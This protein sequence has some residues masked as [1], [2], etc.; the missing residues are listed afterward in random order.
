V[1]TD[2]RQASRQAGK[3]ASKQAG[4]QASRQ[5][6]KQKGSKTPFPAVAEEL[7]RFANGRNG[8]NKVP[9]QKGSR[10]KV[11]VLRHY[12][13]HGERRA[14]TLSEECSL[15]TIEFLEDPLLRSRADRGSSLDS[16][17]RSLGA[18]ELLEDSLFGS[19]PNW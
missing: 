14:L 2:S 11:S 7:L 18:R 9:E 1:E 10:I 13:K 16:E 4:K 5:A 15:V 19:R 8:T 3:Q 6:G 12:K 17:E